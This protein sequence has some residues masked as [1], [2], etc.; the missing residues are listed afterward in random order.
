MLPLVLLPGMDGTGELV[1]DLADQVAWHRPVQIVDYPTREPLGYDDLTALVLDRLPNQRFVILGES[2]SGPIAIE[3]ATR[4][5]L[6]AGLILVSTFARLQIP[7]LVAPL[8]RVF[9]HTRVPQGLVSAGLLGSAGTDDLKARLRA[10]LAKLPPEIIR[11]RIHAVCR[12]DKREALAKVSCPLLYL[13]GRDDRLIGPRHIHEITA[14][15]PDCEVR[16]LAAPHMLLA[17]H[18]SESAGIIDHFCRQLE[19]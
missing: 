11:A 13:Q 15:R 12:V 16:Q 18:P 14:I 4:A 17:T 1:R 19:T 3:V 8:T 9:N 2:F 6:A 5:P 7:S 10:V